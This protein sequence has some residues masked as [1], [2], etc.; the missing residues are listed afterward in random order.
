MVT[1]VT[2]VEIWG[3]GLERQHQGQCLPVRVDRGQDEE[4]VRG[5]ERVD[6]P[7]IRDPFSCKTCKTRGVDFIS[8]DKMVIR[9]AT[10]V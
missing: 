6:V 1:M 10:W 3:G 8:K 9:H 2:M 5:D 4:E 7:H